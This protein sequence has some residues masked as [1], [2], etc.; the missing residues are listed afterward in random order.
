MCTGCR[1]GVLGV[2]DE[3]LS[4]VSVISTTTTTSNLQP[5]SQPAPEPFLAYINTEPTHDTAPHNPQLASSTGTPHASLGVPVEMPT[6]NLFIGPQTI[7]R[8][9]EK[10]GINDDERNRMNKKMNGSWIKVDGRSINEMNAM[11]ERVQKRE[12]GSSI[13]DIDD[14]IQARCF[15]KNGVHLSEE[16]ETALPEIHSVDQGHPS[17]HGR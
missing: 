9:I 14:L 4:G 5:V 7:R 1:D 11:K 12:V 10:N 17:P 2:C 8:M 6:N 16:E 15:L 3:S 13:L